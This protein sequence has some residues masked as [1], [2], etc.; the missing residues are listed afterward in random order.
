MEVERFS[1]PNSALD[2][3]VNIRPIGV[4][5]TDIVATVSN[6]SGSVSRTFPVVVT[7]AQGFGVVGGS[8][9]IGAQGAPVFRPASR[10]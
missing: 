1:F 10:P 2:S 5:G 8:T 4:G 7:A 9:P 6:A 3:I